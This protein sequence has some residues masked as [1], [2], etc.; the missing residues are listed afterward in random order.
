MFK[1]IKKTGKV[2]A[3]LF[4]ILLVLLIAA[5]FFIKSPAGQ[6]WLTQ[7]IAAHFSSKLKTKITIKSVD[8]EFFSTA[9][10]KGV[11]VEDRHGDTLFYADELRAD[12]KTF[13]YSNQYLNVSKIELDDAVVKIKKY[14]NEHG[15][16]YRF[17]QDFFKDTTKSTGSSPWKVDLGSV[18]LKNI[19]VAYIDTRYHEPHRGMNYDDLRITDI[20]AD[21]SNI[22]PMDDSLRLRVNDL[23]A[24][25]KCGFTLSSFSTLLTVSDTFAKFDN[26]KFTTRNGCDVAGFLGFQF[27]DRDD[28]ADDFIH[29]VKM[30]NH[31]TSSIIE[32]QDIA[33]FAP[34][35][36]GMQKKILLTGDVKGT[37]DN[38]R[39]KNIDLRFGEI[40]Q[41]TGDFSFS[42]LPDFETTSMN[43]KIRNARSNKKDL[44]GIPIAPYGDTDHVELP[45]NIAMLGTMTFS[46]NVDGFLNDFVARGTLN[47]AIGRLKLDDLAMLDV[48]D[49]AIVKYDGKMTSEGFNVGQFLAVPN[50]GAITGSAAVKGYGFPSGRNSD[51]VNAD[52][53]GNF[54]SVY[55]YGYSYTGVTV[56]D[57]KL[58]H[59]SFDGTLTINDPNIHL[60]FSGTAD[61]LNTIPKLDFIADIDSADLGALH[62][63]DTTHQHIL[64][65]DMSIKLKGNNIDNVEGTI[66]VNGLQYSKD[67]NNYHFNELTFVAAPTVAGRRI[68]VDSDIATAFIEGNFQILKLPD[69]VRDLMS[70]YLPAYFP[71]PD[72]KKKMD[73]AQEQFISG[74]DFRKN[75]RALQAVMPDVYFSPNTHFNLEFDKNNQTVH[76]ALICL[77]SIDLYGI[78]MKNIQY[79]FDNKTDHS[80][81]GLQGTIQR[82]QI[83]DTVGVDNLLTTL[84]ASN[85]DI[86]AKFN[87]SNAGEKKN[88]GEIVSTIHFVDQNSMNIALVKSDIHVNDSLWNVSKGNSVNIDSSAI[89]IKDLLFQSG[90]QSIG[91]N[92]K[93]SNSPNDQLSVSLSNFNL[94][95]LNYFT[96]KKKV[97]LSGTVSGPTQLMDLYHHASF[98]SNLKFKDL[99]LNDQKI[100][101]GDLDAV[102]KGEGI[103]IHGRFSRNMQVD[104][105]VD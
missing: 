94:S 19:T 2:F 41:L 58:H 47:T 68:F 72:A 53:T 56:T 24:H 7:K 8:L 102:P 59:N 96:L 18:I 84:R 52:V 43:F 39:C 95:Y 60:V 103:Y 16:S 49:S 35:L 48:S 93:I 89:A 62:F 66:L 28:I 86:M 3:W 5:Y 45:D 51:A 99:F 85:N 50:L 82:A 27:H 13:S 77:D 54:S 11:Y 20:N 105:P 63:T 78:R 75:S 67:T 40:S 55:F 30:D 6:T 87:W 46:G 90:S 32:M 74:I 1:I 44:E 69:A 25:E 26:L 88:D 12:I 73:A 4:G 101:D 61:D 92:G 65:T 37:V 42:G 36:K 10:L 79:T 98:N 97:K 76:A 64:S 100:G 17:I 9:V 91:F 21:I 83:N 34:E 80:Y 31:L 23:R 70:N 22:D 29:L 14:A 15:L 38:L 81:I 33:Y 57:G 104:D 71:P